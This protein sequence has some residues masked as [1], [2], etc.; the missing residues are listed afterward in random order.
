[1]MLF[2]NLIYFCAIT[3]LAAAGDP[4]VKHVSHPAL[5][6]IRP[7]EGAGYF[8]ALQ[9]V[10]L[11]TRQYIFTADP[12]KRAIYIDESQRVPL[13]YTMTLKNGRGFDMYFSGADYSVILSVK[14]ETVIDQQTSEYQASLI[15]WRGRFKRKYAV[16]GILNK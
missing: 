16:H 2:I 10:P 9:K 11:H 5:N 7:T 1:M 12:L 3:T 4:F 8:F 14:Q 13:S 6:E 15:V